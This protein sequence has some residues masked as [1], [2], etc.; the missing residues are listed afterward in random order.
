MRDL[1]ML[2]VT[3]LL[4]G[5]PPKGQVRPD[6]PHDGDRPRYTARQDAQADAALQN[7]TQTAEA[8]PEKAIESYLSVRKSFPETTAAQE[9]LFRAGVLYFQAGDFASARKA[10][11]E[12]LFENPLFDK[13]SEAKLYLGISAVEVGACRDGYQTLSSLAERQSGPERKKALEAARDAAECAGLFGEALRIA[14]R[15]VDE[16]PEAEKEAALQAVTD[17]VEGK[18]GFLD[19]ARV[20]QDLA[21]GHPAW[22]IL[23]FKLARIYYHLRD[24]SRLEETLQ[25]F[26]R[27]A[28]SHPYATEA[29]DLLARM[30]RRAEAKPNV[31]GVLLPLSGRYQQVGESVMRG[32]QLALQG[33]DIELVVKDTQGDVTLAGRQVEE[34]AFDEQAIAII[35]PL[36]ADE[37]HRAALVAEELQVPILTLTRSENI[38][39]IGQYVFRNMLTNSQ[40]AQALADYAMSTLGYKTFALLYPNIPFGVELSNQFWDE[41]EARGGEIRGAESYDH[42]QTTFTNEV[43]KLVGRYYLEDRLDYIEGVREINA[44][45]LDSFRRRKAFEKLRGS[46][47]PVVD[48]EALLIP[49]SWQRA[50]LVAPALAV[51]DIITNACDARDLERI[52]KS[53]G[54]RQLKTVTLL[55]TNTWSSPK[56]RSGLPELIERAGK[57]V[58]CSIYVDGFFADSERPATKKFVRAFRE[59]YKDKGV[60]PGLLDATGYDSA[61]MIR[62]LLEKARPQTRS[63]MALKLATL[64]DF[65]GATGKTHF[66]DRRCAQKPLFFLAVEKDGVKE[67]KVKPKPSGS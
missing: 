41:V 65:D 31:V 2:L 55:G 64:K 47:D 60:E 62:H 56:S 42:D 25:A 52:K 27:E 19:V 36:L 38:T 48:F 18:V 4:F 37:S 61:A 11:N 21:T 28:P 44:Q 59:A 29:K 12:L 58:N 43:K 46:L 30:N 5:C 45:N 13:A 34:L 63:E 6:G 1:P 35:G 26:L 51:E 53:T 32:I 16:A 39:S 50:G 54:K 8:E 49:D 66:D 17:L 3:A 24:W 40:Q 22:P 7:A 20:R 15:I 10:F 23:T 14:I 67:L 33:S 9:A 57:F